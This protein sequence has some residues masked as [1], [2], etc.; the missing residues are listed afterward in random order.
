MGRLWTGSLVA[1]HFGDHRFGQLGNAGRMVFR[2][3]DLHPE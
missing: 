2:S 3:A 1:V